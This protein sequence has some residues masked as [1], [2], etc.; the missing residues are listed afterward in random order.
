MRFAP[1]LLL[2]LALSLQVARAGTLIYDFNDADGDVDSNTIDAGLSAGDVGLVSG[3]RAFQNGRAEMSVGPSSAASWSVSVPAGTTLDLTGLSFDYGFNETKHPNPLT[4][5]WTLAITTGSGTPSGN[6][7]PTVTGIGFTSQPETIT[8]NGLT[9]LTDTTVTFTLTFSTAEGRANTLDRA[10]TIDNLTL[11]GSTGVAAGPVIHSFTADDTVVDPGQTITLSWDVSDF[12][13]LT[14]NPGNIDV[15]S[16]PDQQID[17]V[18]NSAVTY[19]LTATSTHGSAH[20]DVPV[21]L[22]SAVPN[23]L[24][25]LIDDMG[26]EDTSVDFNYDAAGNPIAP[27]DPTSVGLPA[28]NSSPGNDHFRTPAMETLAANGMKF[29]RAYAAQVCSPT[30][31]SLLTGQT[32]ARHGT[33]QWLGKTNADKLHNIEAPPAPDMTA[34]DRTLAEVMRDAGYRTIIAGKGHVGSNYSGSA[35]NYINPAP[36]ASDFYGFQVNVCASD[37]GQHK[38]CYSNHSPAFGLLPGGTTGSFVAEYQ[39]KTYKD[40]DSN[41]WPPDHPDAD[42]PVFITEA[43]SREMIER[44]EDSVD[45]G[46]PFFALLSHFA[47]HSPFAPDPRFTANYPGLSGQTLDFATMIEGMDQSLSDVLATLDVRGVAEDTLVIFLGDNG[48]VSQPSDAA[49]NTLGMSNPLQGGKGMRREGGIRVPF[50]VSWAKP[51]PDNPHQQALPIP[52]GSREDDIIAVHDIFPTVLSICGLPLPA[53]D[54]NG[55]PLVIDGSDLSPYLRGTPG[56]HRPQKL[57]TH[58]PCSSRDRFFTTYHEGDWKLIYNYTTESQNTSTSVP[59]GSFE[60][61]NV[62][63]DIHEADNLASAEPA[64]VMSMARAMAAELERYGAP[65]PIL[66]AADASLAALGLPAA[67]GDVHPVILPDSPGVDI[68]GDDLDDNT[69]DPNRNGLM[70]AGETDPDNDDTDGDRLADGAEGLLGLDPL[71]PGEY[72]YLIGTP[73]PDGSLVL[74]WPSQPGTRF[75]INSSPDLSD[76]S[77]VVDPDVPAADPGNSTSYPVPASSAPREF[78][79]V[80][81]K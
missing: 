29:T 24:V 39:N 35:D 46:L 57:I 20:A 75:S 76:W 61:Y 55:A 74:T 44:I 33:I 58:A 54:D 48:S 38:N 71:D 21:H 28:W 51:D 12:D 47:V 6:S 68:D 8:L 43:V 81:L 56:T 3:D 49:G 62:V 42:K 53:T 13:S 66:L 19:T 73:Q 10:H 41:Q 25:V 77:A 34:G 80:G 23:I 22:T 63:T 32:P 70:D 67:A 18:V 40:I 30:R 1:S 50:L 45:E 16:D 79:R 4:P 9:G 15:T 14:I 7:L 59:L 27:I 65:Y 72:F 78:Y 17:V 11:T 2:I 36:P 60:L 52:A 37:K 64:R 5:G 31:V 69:E 26:T